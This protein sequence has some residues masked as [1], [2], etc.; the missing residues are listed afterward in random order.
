MAEDK[1]NTA[2]WDEKFKKLQGMWLSQAKSPTKK[3]SSDNGTSVSL[4]SALAKIESLESELKE[5]R[6]GEEQARK[7]LEDA[8]KAH[9]EELLYNEKYLGG[10]N[11]KVKVDRLE[12]ELKEVKLSRDQV[13]SELEWMSKEHKV[14]LSRKERQIE[15]LKGELIELKVAGKGFSRNSTSD[16]TSTGSLTG[17]SL[18]LLAGQVEL[19]LGRLIQLQDQLKLAKEGQ[20]LTKDADDEK[21]STISQDN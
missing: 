3:K 2:N 15:D 19:C 5:A 20:Q 12:S 11:F 8:N 16:E 4:A 1:E 9:E 17:E 10:L 7:E 6:R 14:E 13:Q 18:N 21:V